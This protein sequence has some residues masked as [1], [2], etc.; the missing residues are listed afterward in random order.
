MSE[1]LSLA[2]G[3]KTAVAE[4][5]N[6]TGTWPA[7]N[8]DARL[9][10]DITG[11]YVKSVEVENGV[12]TAMFSVDASSKLQ[13]AFVKLTP[14]DRGGSVEWSCSGSDSDIKEYVP[15]GCASEP[16]VPSVDP[17]SSV[18]SVDPVSSVSPVD[19]V[20]VSSVSS[21]SSASSDN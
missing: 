16:S 7:T 5:R 9:T 1:A 2:S 11:D 19:P 21:V 3:A 12:I 17:V 18:S 6:T 15:S 4:Y 13:G 10:D 14:V 8:S 20:S